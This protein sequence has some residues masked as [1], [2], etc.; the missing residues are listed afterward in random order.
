MASRSVPG[1]SREA[2][3][4]RP[5]EEAYDPAGAHPVFEYR[6][7]WEPVKAR[8]N[9]QKHGITFEQA[10]TVFNDPL[11]VSI[12]DAD[13]GDTE[14]R[15]VTLGRTRNGTLLV[16]SHTYREAGTNEASVRII[17]A[18]RATNTNAD[19]TSQAHEARVR[20]LQG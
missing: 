8:G 9:R 5:T 11:A 14:Q 1:D 16:I 13:H 20:F 12:P 2:L 4:V 10:A 17:S 3:P 19:S 6:F 18:R 15:W 7:D